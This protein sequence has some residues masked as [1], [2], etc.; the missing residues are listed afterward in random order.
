MS[1]FKS[2]YE[3]SKQQ[4]KDNKISMLK[5]IN[6]VEKISFEIIKGGSDKSKK[7]YLQKGKILPRERIDLLIDKGSPFLEIG[8]FTG[9]D[10][11]DEKIAS[12]GIITGI[13]TI[14][15][16]LCMIICNDATVKG[17]TYYP[18]TVKKHLRAQEIASKNRLPC[19]YL[20]DSGGAYLPSQ[21]QVFPDKTH[22]GRIFYNQ[23]K[24]SAK[25]IPQISVVM[26]SCTAG[27]AYIPALSDQTIIV[28]KQ[29][30][31]F[32]AGPPLVKEATG[33]EV[34][35][36]SLGGAEIHT[37]YSGVADYLVENDYQAI[38]KAREIVKNLNLVQKNEIKTSFSLPL[39]DPEEIISIIP[40]DP[41]KQY[42]VREVIARIVDKSEFDEFKQLYGSELVCVF[43]EIKSQKIGIIANNGIL[44]SESSLKGT[45]FIEICCQRKIPLVFLQN[46]NGFMVGSK[47]E[48]SGIA[49]DGAKLV[50]AVSCANVPKIT[51]IIGG[52]Y[53]AGNYGMCGRAFS[54]NFLWIWPNAKTAVMGGM[55]AA[56]VLSSVKKNSLIKSG[57]SWSKKE[58]ENFKKP[59]LELF[60][61][62]SSALYSSANLWDDGIIDPR[63]T[64]EVISLSLQATNNSKIKSSKFPVYRM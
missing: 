59:I 5:E 52:S 3:P 58:E 33:E 42:D 20:V 61:K 56:G 64:R 36:E 14:N 21:D 27:G 16:N 40:D 6:K 49:K 26:G 31:I 47:Y 41:K 8:L 45:H 55:Q 46:I 17:G 23:S 13:G 37:I 4:A 22:F 28:K 2:N 9:Y 60:E 44:M 24:M 32:L 43:S 53:G 38:H 57:N 34:D 39:Y 1:T 10:L 25:G 7:K 18:L 11:Y 35:A 29:G 30:T 19:V 15:D 12:A 48:K 54:P 51:I 63:K 50:A 62:Q